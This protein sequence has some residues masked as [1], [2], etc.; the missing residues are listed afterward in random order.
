MTKKNQ[1]SEATHPFR[2]NAPKNHMMQLF[3][4]H[5]FVLHNLKFEFSI[6]WE[7]KN[8][9]HYSVWQLYLSPKTH[10]AKRFELHQTN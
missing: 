8:T 7:K 10:L 4:S 2:F 5:I 1:F 9:K 3:D 6:F